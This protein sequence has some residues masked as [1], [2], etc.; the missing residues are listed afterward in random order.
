MIYL[1]S[2][3]TTQVDP[4]VV[5]A[6]L[7]FLTEHYANPSSSYGAARKVRQAV[8]HAR[9]Q[10]AALIGCQPGEL[11]FMSCGTEANNAALFSALTLHTPHRRHLVT[12]KTEHSAVLEVARRWV[13][14]GNPTTFLDVDESGEV[15]PEE[16]S[17]C[18]Q[19]G[20]TAVVSVM[21]ANN[22]TGVIQ[23]I[24]E[25]VKFVHDRGVLFHTDAVQAVGKVPISLKDLPVD[26]LSLAGHKFHAPKGIGALYVS[27]RVRFKPWMLG[28]G[29]EAGRR[30]G[31]ENVPHIVALGK[32]AEL[33]R[34]ELANGGDVRVREMRDTFESKVRAA[35]PEII[36]NSAAANRLGTTSSMTFPDIDAP[37]LLILLDER[38]VACSAGSACHTG[39]LHPS[40]ALEAMGLD[41]KH[42]GST[43][44]FSWSRLNTM[45]ET[46]QAA[47]ALIQCVHKMRDL[48]AGSGDVVVRG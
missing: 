22:E 10:V 4:R 18:V 9:E 43:L 27:K 32:A 25:I 23:P 45:E 13:E 30:S 38:G 24:E 40:H 19:P 6:M 2:N 20:Q 15:H 47:D 33:M 14:E 26:Y 16:W 37:G 46:H 3:A 48:G 17:R 41:A 8:D 42:A 39:A 35:I 44:R 5:E 11:I 28:G 21:W 7:P 1:D 31:T 34:E 29:Q 36:V 12:A